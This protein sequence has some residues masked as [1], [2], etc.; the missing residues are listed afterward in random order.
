VALAAP[1][2]F[3]DSFDGA[4]VVGTTGEFVT[5]LTGTLA[6]GRLFAGIDEAVIGARVDLNLG[7]SLTPAHG[8]GDAAEHDA[9]AGFSYTVVGVMQPTGTPWDRAVLVP[10]EGVWAVH[11]LATGHAP[12]RADQIGPPFDAAYFPGTPAV[13]LRAD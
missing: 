10:L 11:G 13:L 5:H 4:P 8:V 1:I 6:E 9:H 3:G 7:D 12:E 2:A